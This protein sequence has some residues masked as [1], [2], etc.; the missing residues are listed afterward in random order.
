MKGLPWG[1][2][3]CDTTWRLIFCLFTESKNSGYLVCYI[4][5][6]VG[7]QNVHFWHKWIN[8][9]IHFKTQKIPCTLT[10]T[11]PQLYNKLFYYMKG[12][13]RVC[14]LKAW[15]TWRGQTPECNKM[16]VPEQTCDIRFIIRCNWCKNTD[17]QF[18]C[19][20]DKQWKGV[21]PYITLLCKN[22]GTY[23]FVVDLQKGLWTNQKQHCAG[24]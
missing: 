11:P 22:S 17:K 19:I 3:T 1:E 14:P 6:S 12:F 7:H 21:K 5:M 24:I 2:Y 13:V 4:V 8:T 18:I 10:L 9:F 15:C 16:F 20:T 23:S